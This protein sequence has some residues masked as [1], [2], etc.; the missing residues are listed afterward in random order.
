MARFIALASM[1]GPVMGLA[2]LSAFG[3]AAFARDSAPVPDFS[4]QWART[5]LGFESPAS[6]RGP[7][8]NRMRRPAGG[9]NFSKLVGDYA[10]PLL[11]PE[12][13][14]TLRKRGEISLMNEAFP[15]PSNQC[16]PY[17]PPYIASMNQE[18]EL[19]QEKDRVTILNMFDHQVRHVRLN[20]RHPARLTPSWY[21]D[22]I[23]HYEGGTLVVDTVGI[24]PGPLPMVDIYGTPFSAALHVIERFRLI[25]GK[26]ALEADLQSERDNQRVGG[27]NGDGVDIDHAYQGKGLQLQFTVEDPGVFTE[28]WTATVTYLRAAG[29]W[30]E[31]VCAENTREY[32]AG[33]DTAIP[34][35]E[36]PDF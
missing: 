3:G 28:P 34:V 2:A 15:Q 33:K 35:A 25:D 29:D 36:T 20:G 7:I 19:L 13:A 1:L 5:S 4:G 16:L 12:A 27:E 24:K 22:S 6:G 18:I 17:P 23:G 31:M 11:K 30:A 26:S 32:Y 14:E 9:S 8:A 21:G 10:D